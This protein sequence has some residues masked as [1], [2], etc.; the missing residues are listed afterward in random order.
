M[1]GYRLVGYIA[2][3]ESS[4]ASPLSFCKL[5]KPHTTEVS[6]SI[7]PQASELSGLYVAMS[8][9]NNSIYTETLWEFLGTVLPEER[10]RQLQE[11]QAAKEKLKCPSANPFLNDWT[12]RLNTPLEP[13]SR[14]EHVDR[15]KKDILRNMVK[16]PQRDGKLGAKSTQRPGHAAPQRSSNTSQRAVVVRPEQ[17]RKSAKPPVGLV[18]SMSHRTQPRG[19]LSASNSD[20]LNPERNKKPEQETVTAA[21]PQSRTDHCPP[22][23]PCSLNE[24]LQ[25]R[26]VCN[27]ENVQAQASIHPVRNRVFQSDGNN[28]GNKRVLAH[29][30]SSAIMSRTITGPK[31]RINNCQAKEEPIQDKFRKT[32]PGSKSASQKTGVKTQPLQPPRLL[33]AST[34]LLHKKP[35]ANQEKTNVA[36]EP[37][38][39]PLGIVPVGVLKNHSRPSQLKRS[40][41][42]HLPFSRPQGT[43][44]LKSS[45]KPGSTVP[46]QRPMAKGEA[47]R[48]DVKVVPPG[49][50]AASQVTV[51]QNQPRSVHSSK[52]QAIEHDFCS[53]TDRLKPKLPTASGVHAGRVPKAPSAVDRK[54]QLEEW[55]ASKGKTYKRPPM[56]L[57]QKKAVK[58]SWRNVKEKENQE[59]PEQLCLE[60]INNI[61]TECLKL[62]EEG[63][64]A[65]DVSAVLSQ[66]PQAEKFAK[67]W[68]CK[69]KLLARSGPFDVTGLY[70]A[71]VCAGAVP[72]QELRE[73]VLDIL[74]AADR[75]SEGEK[76]GQPIPWEPATPCLSE[77]QHVLVTP[78]LTGR[79]LTSLPV[80]IKLQVTSASRGK[81]FLEGQELKFLTPV[82]RSVRIERAGSRYPEML[83]DHDPLVSSLS[84][85][86]DAEEET[87][88]FFR[89]NKA[90]P[91]VAE[92]EG[93]RLYPPECC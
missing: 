50:T 78:S 18:P 68:I 10:R 46:W 57:L 12:N 56:M 37:V 27:I 70:K 34:T 75:T 16:G 58:L 21:A 26:L 14:L 7:T 69:A 51:P 22:E 55:L 64:Q 5:T 41:T 92:L 86:L 71:A 20:H 24:G 81:E 74:K 39:K 36:R 79:S 1:A 60:K 90:L 63:V 73:V 35:W 11:Y 32:L 13:V 83:K 40:P 84:E 23:A 66:V 49:R 19:R 72:L 42:K 4:A 17:P 33:T 85:I 88:F 80:S 25:D 31:D 44:N 93:L 87:Q 9:W 77:R 89:K 62:I 30:Q 48:K 82:R 53:R 52:T 45:L 65:E 29:R 38:G 67:F 91:E 47:A 76:A 6:N 2:E 59:K 61:L 8:L 28:L 43:T 15:N 54:K 3:V